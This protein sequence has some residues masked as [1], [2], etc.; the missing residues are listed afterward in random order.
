MLPPASAYRGPLARVT[1][2]LRNAS[3]IDPTE[4]GTTD[5]HTHKHAHAQH[6]LVIPGIHTSKCVRPP[7]PLAQHAPARVHHL[8]AGVGQRHQMSKRG[9]GASFGPACTSSGRQTFNSRRGE[10]KNLGGIQVRGVNRAGLSQGDLVPFGAIFQ[11]GPKT[12]VEGQKSGRTIA[13][14]IPHKR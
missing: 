13:H 4:L 7:P 3:A 6:H 1:I 10:G 12:I 8:L 11:K 2:C 14:C 9:Q 5:L